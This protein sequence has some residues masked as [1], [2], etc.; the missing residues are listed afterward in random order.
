MQPY[1]D[2][3]NCVSSIIENCKREIFNSINKQEK[4]V[5]VEFEDCGKTDHRLYDLLKDYN[6][7]ISIIKTRDDGSD[8]IV[9]KI[10]KYTYSNFKICGV[11]TDECVL[12]TIKG[13]IFLCP[14]TNIDIVSDSVN[15]INIH[16]QLCTLDKMKTLA[17]TKII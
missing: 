15:T 14:N 7:L 6:N 2:I 10:G 16:K 5:L 4:I 8:A 9:E 17:R 11:N 3:N 12:S 13:L 1:F